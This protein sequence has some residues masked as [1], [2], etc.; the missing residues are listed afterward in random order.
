MHRLTNILT[1][2]NDY[3]T[4]NVCSVYRSNI[5]TINDLHAIRDGLDIL[6]A[7]GFTLFTPHPSFSFPAF[8]TLPVPSLPFLSPSPSVPLEVG[9]L[10]TV[11]GS[12]CATSGV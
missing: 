4:A 1:P 9:P 8:F 11:R 5:D 12:G 2:F 10:Y 7:L 3:I 6:R